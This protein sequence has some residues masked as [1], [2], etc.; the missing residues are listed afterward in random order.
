VNKRVVDHTCGNVYCKTCKDY[1]SSEHQCYML[2]V[3]YNDRQKKHTYIFFEFECTQDDRIQCQQG[4]QSVDNGECIH[5][6][7]PRCGAFEHKPNLC[8]VHRVCLKC[9][10]QGVDKDSIC[11]TC[12]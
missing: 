12:V 6:K 1:Y 4:Y 9:M 3:D 2:P 11:Q 8:V 5:C 10:D 7:S